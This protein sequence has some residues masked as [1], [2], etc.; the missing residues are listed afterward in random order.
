[1]T[2]HRQRVCHLGNLHR[3]NMNTCFIVYNSIQNQAASRQDYK[4]ENNSGICL[5]HIF[6]M[7]M[8]TLTVGL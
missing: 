4:K 5:T 7:V 1:M 8:L 2:T 3:I 6:I